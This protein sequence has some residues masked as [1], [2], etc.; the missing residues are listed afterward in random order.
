MLSA[1]GGSGGGGRGSADRIAPTASPA[2]SGPDDDGEGDGIAWVCEGHH[3]IGKRLR[4][5]F[6][7]IYADA[8]V[9]AWV[10]EEGDDQA[11]FSIVQ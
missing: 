9:V 4:R 1:V 10:P 8:T 11:L 7:K 5:I 3:F 2:G 6:G